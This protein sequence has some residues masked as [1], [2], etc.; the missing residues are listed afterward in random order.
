[1]RTSVALLSVGLAFALAACRGEDKTSPVSDE[2]ARAFLAVAVSFAQSGEIDRLCAA[3]RAPKSTCR[4]HFDLRGAAAV[5]SQAPMVIAS[6]ALS[7]STDNSSHGRLLTLCGIDGAGGQYESGFLVYRQRGGLVAPYPIFW[8]GIGVL[9]QLSPSPTTPGQPEDA[10][11]R[12]R[13]AGA[14]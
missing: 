2:D 7:P 1:M 5:P 11:A 10:L 13:Q 12:C 3:T 9:I 4:T 6:D 14:F 8:S